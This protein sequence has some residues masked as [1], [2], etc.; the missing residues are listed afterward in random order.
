M[1]PALRTTT[2][3][4]AALLVTAVLA[5]GAPPAATA[6]PAGPD[7]VAEA[8]AEDGLDR[9]LLDPR[10]TE[11]SGLAR[12][13]Y[14]DRLLW[15]H[16]DTGHGPEL[17]LVGRDGRT[18]AM[19][20]LGDATAVD[21]EALSR[22]KDREGTP[23]LAVGDIGDNTRTRSEIAVHVLREPRVTED[24]TVP[25][26]EVTT[27]RFRYEAGRHDAE[28]LLVH[29]WTGRLYVVTKSYYGGRVYEAPEE[30]STQEVN[31]LRP[32][33][34]APRT[35][36]DGAF[37]FDGRMVLRDYHSAHVSEGP[38]TPAS[39]VPLPPTSQGESLAPLPGNAGILV[40]SEGWSSPVYRVRLPKLSD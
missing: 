8:D 2:T 5:M 32:V 25:P 31:V 17:F 40:G 10:I 4:A 39:V 36:T 26:S 9:R 29:P 15:T 23:W 28:A 19:V 24:T 18:Q 33:A 34:A 13:G 3:R 6:A 22:Y 30:L 14:D 11:S 12:S 37:L 1:K 16:N 35:V 27:Y 20:T 7:E 38:G 21:W